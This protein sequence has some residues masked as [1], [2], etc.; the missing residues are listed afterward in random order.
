MRAA[1]EIQFGR[2]GDAVGQSLASTMMSLTSGDHRPTRQVDALVN[3]LR[4]VMAGREVSE[5]Q[6]VEL[7]QCVVNVLRGQASNF[8]LAAQVRQQLTALRVGEQRTDQIVKRF[9]ALGESVRGPDD[10]PVF[11]DQ[12]K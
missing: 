9:I 1:D 12:L 4:G 2:T 10:I 3:A 8:T 7:S 5:G 11:V 6:A